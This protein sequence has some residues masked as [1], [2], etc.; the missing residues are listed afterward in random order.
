MTIDN[1]SLGCVDSTAYRTKYGSAPGSQTP[2]LT[3]A[4]LGWI[5]QK[6]EMT[7]NCVDGFIKSL[8]LTLGSSRP[9]TTDTGILFTFTCHLNL[10]EIN[11]SPCGEGFS[12]FTFTFHLTLREIN[13]SPC[14]EGFSPFTFTFHLDLREIK[15][16]PC[17]ESL[18]SCS[19]ISSRPL[20]HLHVR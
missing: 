10:E 4:L 12:H 5:L 8:Y 7:H 15:V 11:V 1:L 3:I 2:S 14:G 17:C 19:G 9:K 18:K 6:Y 16:S 13:V 20:T